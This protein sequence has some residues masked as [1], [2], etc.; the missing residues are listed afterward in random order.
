MR[1]FG[2]EAVRPPVRR[3]KW[4]PLP[5]PRPRPLPLRLPRRRCR[6]VG[7]HGRGYDG[8][9]DPAG[10]V[11]AVGPVPTLALPRVAWKEEKAD[12]HGTLASRV[13]SRMDSAT[14]LASWPMPI[15]VAR[16]PPALPQ[17][18]PPSN[19]WSHPTRQTRATPELPPGHAGRLVLSLP[20]RRSLP[21]DT[22]VG[23]GENDYRTRSSHE[24]RLAT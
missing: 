11:R 21:L 18:L 4:L 1:I 5:P 20:T 15:A 7:G 12:R 6:H 14:M 22:T 13:V 8:M 9:V 19:R 23:D 3:S 2:E 10:V 24:D 17:H 16:L